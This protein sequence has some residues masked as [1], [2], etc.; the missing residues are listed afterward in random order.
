MMMTRTP[1]RKNLY[2]RQPHR[3]PRGFPPYQHPPWGTNDPLRALGTE[4]LIH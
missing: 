3:I 1:P 2:T 4:S